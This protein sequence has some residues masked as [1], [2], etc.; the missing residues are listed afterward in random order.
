MI[1]KE[2]VLLLS[3]F[4]DEILEL[5]EDQ[6]R[7]DGNSLNQ[8][9]LQGSVMV[10]VMK[11]YNAGKKH[12]EELDQ[13]KK[14]G[15]GAKAIQEIKAQKAKEANTLQPLPDWQIPKPYRKLSK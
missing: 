11:I 4:E 9:D 14:S 12:H 3:P 15:I 5:I 10:I 8:S 2:Q 1:T 7:N 6:V 13:S